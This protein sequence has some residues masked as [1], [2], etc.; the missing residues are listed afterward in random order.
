MI[1]LE[2]SKSMSGTISTSRR[3]RLNMPETTLIND[4]YKIEDT[5]GKGGMAVV[6]KARDLTLERS[7]AIKVLRQEYST[8]PAF[9][10]HFHQEAKAAANLSHP[11]I[12]TVHDFGFDAERL[13]IIMEYV[14][15][16]DLKQ[17]LDD[18]EG[19]GIQETL[20]LMDQACAGVGYAHRAGLVHCDI[21]PQNLLITPDQRL[22]VVDFGI[23]RALVSIRPDEKADIVWGSPHY[24][25]PEQAAGIAPSPAS[26]VYSIGVITYEMLTGQLPF[27]ASSSTELA[28]MH[29]Q[30]LPTAPRELNPEISPELEQILLKVLSKEPAARYR[31][32]DQLGRVLHTLQN[33]PSQQKNIHSYPI[34]AGVT[35]AAATQPFES[36]AAPK[37][38]EQKAD[39]FDLDWITIILALFALITVGGLI[40]FALWVYF[41]YNP[42]IR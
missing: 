20:T 6:Y 15:G 36:P 30:D 3:I 7:V 13:F 5:L 11:N 1:L 12:V 33:E 35:S 31:T 19:F 27:S 29:R 40:P 8:N 24:F 17:L 10:E 14:P 9:R 4:R 32:A 26:D 22:K 2:I 42:P 41:V 28:R 21:K 37:T 25:S 38:F 23:A 18:S 34:A 39:P 16:T